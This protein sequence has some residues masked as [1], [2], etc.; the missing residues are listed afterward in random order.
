MKSP[1]FQFYPKDWLSSRRVRMMTDQQRGWYIQLLC[2]AWESEIQATLP[3]DPKQLWILAGASDEQVFNT[4][5]SPVLNM[6]ERRDGMLIN[7]RL[8]E[9]VA[10]QQHMSELRS[11]A[12]KESGKIRRQHLKDK[13][14]ARVNKCSTDVEQTANTPSSIASASA[15]AFA[16]K[17]ETPSLNTK[18]SYKPPSKFVHQWCK[19][20]RS[21]FNKEYLVIDVKDEIGSGAISGIPAVNFDQVL[22]I[23]KKAWGKDSFWCKHAL[24]LHGFAK[25]FNN[26][27][28]EVGE[29]KATSNASTYKLR[30]SL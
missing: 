11:K 5:S 17:E 6:F 15:I 14:L 9:E 13:H 23:A 16:N 29:L 26:I 1:A 8:A 18:K 30:P 2:E 28:G 4:C 10:K 25:H 12:G 27:C 20:Y 19:E 7:H 24:T 22:Q 3:D 21:F